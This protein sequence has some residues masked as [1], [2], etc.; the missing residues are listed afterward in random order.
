MKK[1]K[2]TYGSCCMGDTKGY[3]QKTEEFSK[4]WYFS[5]DYALNNKSF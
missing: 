3:Q 4:G 2:K 5:Q 1:T